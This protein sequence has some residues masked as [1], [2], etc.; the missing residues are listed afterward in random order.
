[1][2]IGVIDDETNQLRIEAAAD[3]RILGQPFDRQPSRADFQVH[4]FMGRAP[5]EAIQPGVVEGVER[6]VVADLKEVQAA[7][8]AFVE[9]AVLVERVCRH[10]AGYADR[11][12]ES[13]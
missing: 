13:V 8:T 4:L 9:K 5:G 10:L 7:G 11:P 3:G 1:M 6:K 12:T 2:I